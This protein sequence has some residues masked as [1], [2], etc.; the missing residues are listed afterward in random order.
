[1]KKISNKNILITGASGFIGS[2]LIKKL[3]KK[4]QCNIYAT[5]HINNPKIK[6]IKI[7]YQKVDLKNINHCLKITKNIDYVFMCAA[8]SSGAKV[9]QENP[10]AHFSPNIIMNTN[11]LE[12]SHKNNVKKFIFISSSTVYPLTNYPVSE[13]DAKFIFFEKYYIV[14]WMKRF[15]EIMCNIYKDK[16]KNPMRTLIIRPGNLYG[17]YDKFN[18]EE[19]KVIP[20][21]IRKVIEKK[22]PIEVWGDGKDLKDF[23]YIEDF[24][25]ALIKVSFNNKDV[26]IINIA[27]GRTI[28]VKSILKKILKIEKLRS[29]IYFDNSKPVLIPRRSINISK[30][31]TMFKFKQKTGLELGLKKTIQWY[32]S[33]Y[34][35]KSPEDIE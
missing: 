15:S 27:S 32:K 3:L 18:N 22:N 26:G 1:M 21:L 35:F 4:K 34:K 9:I 17:V 30:L 28:T 29:K 8:N 6:N 13:K 14:A 7:N 33:Y 25:E 20:A 19:S 10:L 2:N 11:M 31:K 16:I 5:I 12:A 23:L 24:I